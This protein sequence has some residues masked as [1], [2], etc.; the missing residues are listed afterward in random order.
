MRGMDMANAMPRRGLHAFSG[1]PIRESHLT[2]RAR[3]QIRMRRMGGRYGKCI[4]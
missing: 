1:R 2:A 3:M 4:P